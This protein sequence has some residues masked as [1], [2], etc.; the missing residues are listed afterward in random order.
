MKFFFAALLVVMTSCTSDSKPA[1]SDSIK[2]DSQSTA[3][4]PI[5]AVNTGWNEIEAGPVLLVAGSDN[6]A[7]A[8][9][10]NPMLNDS[11]LA[12]VSQTASDS[13]SGLAVD[14]FDRSGFVSTG[15]LGA[16][17]QVSASEGCLAW[18]V[19]SLAESNQKQWQA[20]FR[21]GVVTALGLDSLEGFSSADSMAV[22]AE[23][24]RLASALPAAGDSAF[25]GLPFSVRK[26]YR[27]NSSQPP[28]L[29]GD[30]VRKI[31][32]EANPRE[33]HLL[34]VAEKA[35][36]GSQYRTV[37]HTRATGSE[38][39]VQTTEILAAGRLVHSGK[40]IIVVSFGYENGN[41]VALIERSGNSQWRITWRSAYT[42]C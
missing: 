24:A 16:R 35:P 10:V 30:I 41:R 18:P 23:L 31:N 26:A 22:T 9:V 32:E 28:L 7:T 29:I 12:A 33:E 11:L 37:F 5:P 4:V 15:R 34:L 27:T 20:G 36:S 3:A 19:M 2:S 8:S 14:L 39:Q 6:A 17:T 38:E 13:L 42:G 40:T 21:K 1:A 25:Q